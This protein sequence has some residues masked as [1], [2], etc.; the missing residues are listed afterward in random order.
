MVFPSQTITVQDPG[1]A[2]AQTGSVP[3]LITGC[4][5]GGSTAVT[6]VTQINSV[7]QVRSVIGYGPLAEDV[8]LALQLSGGP[9][10]FA[11]HN[12]TGSALS[13]QAMTQK[14]GSGTAPTLSGTPRDRYGVTI[15]VVLGG[16][17]GTAT[18]KFSLDNWTYDTAASATSPTYSNVY[19]TA[20]TYVITNSGLTINFGAGTYVAGDTFFYESTPGEVTTTDLG[21]IATAVQNDPT[22]PVD[23]W[24][25]SGTQVVQNT[26]ATLAAAFEGDLVALTNS[27][28]YPRGLIDIGSGD[29]EAH[30]HTA[31][32]SW[33][34]VRVCPAY[35]YEIVASALPFEGF[36][37]R[38]VSC[39][40][41]IGIRAFAEEISS[42][43]SRTAAG[44]C[45]EA[46]AIYFDGFYTQQLDGDQ[47]STMRTWV[48]KPGFYIAGAKLKCSFGSNFTDLQFGRVMDKACLTTYNGQ[49]PYQSAIFRATSTGTVDPR[50]AAS[51]EAAVQGLLDDALMA[52]INSA[53]TPGHVSSILYSVDLT[54]NIV[55]TSQLT[56]HVAMVPLGYAKVISTTLAFQ[57][58]T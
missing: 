11:I 46:V 7:S 15:I 21:T 33:T 23:L 44:A 16:A 51:L 38:K 3:P 6:T 26:A 53:G 2:L 9:I 43:L 20:S 47:I 4:S 55:T 35:G 5:N 57:I 24:M 41:S 45:S 28:R 48:G 36:S 25:I 30:V 8:A 18:F 52:P 29:T 12:V 22:L 27:F 40:T 13:S 54:T 17:V 58:S 42:D 49:F 31:A 56:T 34:G 39:V 19:T 37:F 14:V 1:I 50:D 10:N 32:S